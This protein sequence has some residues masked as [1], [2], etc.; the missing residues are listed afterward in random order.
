MSKS[1][2]WVCAVPW[3]RL[4][5]ESWTDRVGTPLPL[6]LPQEPPTDNT[7]RMW[8]RSRSLRQLARRWRRRLWVRRIITIAPRQ[9]L[10]LR[11]RLGRLPVPRRLHHPE[12]TPLVLLRPSEY[13]IETEYYISAVYLV[14]YYSMCQ[15]YTI[16]GFFGD[17]KCEQFVYLFIPINTSNTGIIYM[18]YNQ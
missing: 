14:F 2:T 18:G 13:I 10:Q 3:I 7:C 4:A 8:T 5:A 12:L 16:T 17:W 15:Q 1:G 9:Q 6:G 11:W